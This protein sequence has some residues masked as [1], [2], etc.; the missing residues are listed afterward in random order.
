[1]RDADARGADAVAPEH[2]QRGDLRQPRRLASGRGLQL[3]VDAVGACHHVGIHIVG[4]GA[5]AAGAVVGAAELSLDIALQRIVGQHAGV[6]L[7]MRAVVGVEPVEVA[8]ETQARG[9][10]FAAR[11]R[12]HRIQRAPVAVEAGDAGRWSGKR[13]CHRP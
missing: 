7:G 2:R 11:Q 4:V 12:F 1:M 5:T 8:V 9:P 10:G 13:R 3:A 6:D